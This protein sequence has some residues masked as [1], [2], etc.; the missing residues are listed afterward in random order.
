MVQMRVGDGSMGVC[1][2]LTPAY[3]HTWRRPDLE[4]PGSYSSHSLKATLLSWACAFGL[5]EETRSALGYHVGKQR[6]RSV[7][8]YARDHLLD[9]LRKLEEMMEAIRLGQ[10]VPGGGL[11]KGVALPSLAP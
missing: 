4:N 10:F 7:N 11:G 9:P 6:G 3:G 2:I 8:V 5:D 1:R